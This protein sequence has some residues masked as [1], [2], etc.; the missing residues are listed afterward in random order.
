MAK[1]KTRVLLPG[2]I[3]GLV[4][5]LQS[6]K[7]LSEARIELPQEP[8]DEQSATDETKA[9]EPLAV[10][11]V[12]EQPATAQS[13]AEPSA[14]TQP[15]AGPAA[16]P[17]SATEPS[18]T[19]K[20]SVEPS[21]TSQP[22]A[23]ADVTPSQDEALKAEAQPASGVAG[24]YTVPEPQEIVGRGRPQKVNTMKEYTIVKDDSSDSWDLFLDLAQQYKKGGG[25]L[26]TIYIDEELKAVLD[27]M[28][29]AGKER[30]STSAILSSI[31]ARFIYDHADTI[32]D[33]LYRPLN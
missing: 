3:Q 16:T 14:T 21:A 29:Y 1:K 33:I 27:R 19:A 5:D 10:Q 11:P 12:E 4:H 2:G 32:K 18:A 6:G 23:A 15:A 25:K 28:K 7:D 13:A 17:Q 30:L 24:L 20:P 31:V 22:A 26:A 8:K 9:D